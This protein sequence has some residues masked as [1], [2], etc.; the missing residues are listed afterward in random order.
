MA[1]TLAKQKEDSELGIKKTVR[2]RTNSL[3]NTNAIDAMNDRVT[4]AIE[5][6]F[7]PHWVLEDTANHLALKA[8]ETEDDKWLEM[9]N[10]LSTQNGPQRTPNNTW[11]LRKIGPNS[12]GK[13]LKGKRIVLDAM[14]KLRVKQ[15]K[16]DKDAIAIFNHQQKELK[17]AL[18]REASILYMQKGSEGWDAKWTELIVRASNSGMSGVVKGEKEN[19][20]NLSTDFR[21]ITDAEFQDATTNFIKDTKVRDLLDTNFNYKFTERGYTLTEKQEGDLKQRIESL[22]NYSQIKEVKEFIADSGELIDKMIE[23]EKQR[24]YPHVTAWG[25]SVGLDQAVR[26]Q[27]RE[28]EEEVKNIF[29]KHLEKQREENNKVIPYN[30]W[31]KDAKTAFLEEVKETLNSIIPKQDRNGAFSGPVY[32]NIAK[33]FQDNKPLINE[34]SKEK[35]IKTLRANRSDIESVL[36]KGGK[37]TKTQKK[38]LDYINTQLDILDLKGENIIQKSIEEAQVL[39]ERS[40]LTLTSGDERDRKLNNKVTETLIA[41][42]KQSKE[43]TEDAINNLKDT[44][45]VRFG[46]AAEAKVQRWLKAIVAPEDTH[47]TK[48]ISKYYKSLVRSI[49]PGFLEGFLDSALR[50]DVEKKLGKVPEKAI[51]LI[52]KSTENARLIIEGMMGKEIDRIKKPYLLWENEERNAFTKSVKEALTKPNKEQIKIYKELGINEAAFGDKHLSRL[53]ALMPRDE[54]SMSAKNLYSDLKTLGKSL[55]QLSKDQAEIYYDMFIK[56]GT[57]T[58]S[59]TKAHKARIEALGLKLKTYNPK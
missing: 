9:I 24:L 40:L 54:V 29:I 27:K 42:A 5:Q 55:D 49:F 50:F 53:R 58:G 7:Q 39:R 51:G 15:G 17:L 26:E 14:Q 25:P 28:A 19:I 3:T 44:A 13:T 30:N 8:I 56:D 47:A 36:A 59:G 2:N 11:D 31:E 46:T 45:Q 37:L 16:K 20:E 22:K 38:G 34:R 48:R 52:D 43:Y 12:Y 32:E 23:A 35:W 21:T 10:Y 33:A 57:V 1:D 4:D 41:G 6:G 18:Q